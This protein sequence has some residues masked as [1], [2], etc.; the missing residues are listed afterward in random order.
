MDGKRRLE[1]LFLDT[2]YKVTAAGTRPIFEGSYESY[3]I[4]DK[5]HQEIKKNQSSV[6][7]CHV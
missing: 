6:I 3:H 1:K 5:L 4:L 7:C 2:L